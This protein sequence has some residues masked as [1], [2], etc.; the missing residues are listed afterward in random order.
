MNRGVSKSGYSTPSIANPSSRRNRCVESF[1]VCSREHW[2]RKT[3]GGKTARAP[4]DRS[5]LLKGAAQ[6]RPVWWPAV[7]QGQTLP[8]CTPRGATVPCPPRAWLGQ[9]LPPTGLPPLF[10][11]NESGVLSAGVLT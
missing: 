5:D 10:L 9:A 8:M 1:L 3:L 4:L 7:Q 6:A 11:R 2:N